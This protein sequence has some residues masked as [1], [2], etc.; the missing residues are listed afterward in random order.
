[1][2]VVTALNECL[3][4]ADQ[5]DISFQEKNLLRKLRDKAFSWS[6]NTTRQ[7]TILD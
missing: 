5:E 7:S 2:R 4:W 6:L 3:E 1:M